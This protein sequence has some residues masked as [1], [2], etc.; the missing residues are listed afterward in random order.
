MS[1]PALIVHGG[2]GAAEDDLHDARHAGCRAAIEV[3]WGILARGGSALD[4]VCDA[5]AVLESDPLF[6]AGVG[7][8]LTRNG[9]VEMDASV[10]DGSSL[11]AGAVA[12]VCAVRNPVRIARALL[13]DGQ[14][15]MLA[16]PAADAFAQQHGVPTCRPEDLITERQRERWKQRGREAPCG[17]TVGAAAVDRTGHVAAVTSTGGIFFKHPGRIGDSAVIGAGTYADDLQGAA[18]ATGY[19]EAIIRTALA[20]RVVDALGSGIDPVCAAREGISFLGRRVKGTGGIIVVDPLGRIGH[21]F[22][23]AHM[24]LGYMRSDLAVPVI[25]A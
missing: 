1:R 13:E 18:S 17:A 5:V 24:T 20:R 2:A 3:G 23:T 4:A 6:N 8:C 10:M 16:G 19:G 15:V 9:T 25:E 11:R 22:N 7:S 21:A 12:V 14:H